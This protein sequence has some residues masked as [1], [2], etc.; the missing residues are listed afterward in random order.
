MSVPSELVQAAVIAGGFSVVV[1]LIQ[2]HAKNNRVDHGV[3]AT[4]LD[5]L[6]EGHSRIEAKIDSHV[7]DHAKGEFQP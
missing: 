7:T 1:A 3:V 4:K 2:K 6:A 5:H